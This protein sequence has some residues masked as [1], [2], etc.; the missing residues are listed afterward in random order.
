MMGSLSALA[1]LASESCGS[2][3]AE[4]RRGLPGRCRGVCTEGWLLTPPP[5]PKQGCPGRFLHHHFGHYNADDL[6]H[7]KQGYEP[8]SLPG[9]TLTCSLS[10]LALRGVPTSPAGRT[11]LLPALPWHL[12]VRWQGWDRTLP[13]PVLPPPAELSS[14]RL[15][16]VCFSPPLKHQCFEAAF[17]K[18]PI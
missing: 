17:W 11:Q 3:A 16:T 10:A 8:T 12:P 2:G 18:F 15:K 6:T 14:T 9:G 1:G 5:A 7:N 13:A 4:P